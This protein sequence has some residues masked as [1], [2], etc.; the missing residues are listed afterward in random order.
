VFWIVTAAVLGAVLL[1]AWF[2]DRRQGVDPTRMPTD[3][4]QAP[5]EADA[6]ATQHRTGGGISGF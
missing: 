5:A 1:G 4:R 3:A 6:D 2:Y